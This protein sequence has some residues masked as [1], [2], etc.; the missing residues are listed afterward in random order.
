MSNKVT[1]STGKPCCILFLLSTFER[2]NQR[3]F[4]W[5]GG[6]AD[7]KI[8]WVKW[9]QICLPKDKGGLGVKNL[10]LF[11][12]SLLSKWKWRLLS[13]EEASWTD[14]LRFRYGHFPTLLLGGATSNNRNKE[15]IW[16]TDIID[17]GKGLA[18]DWFRSNVGCNV[19]NGRSTGF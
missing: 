17:T 19:G 3:N 2:G 18:E 9:D 4:L 7:K 11:N 16:W 6:M 10:E 15:S 5:G 12:L 1:R 13:D 14:L 8:C